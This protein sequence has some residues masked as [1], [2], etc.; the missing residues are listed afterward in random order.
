VPRPLNERQS[1]E[2][3]RAEIPGQIAAYRQELEN[4][5]PHKARRERLEWQIRERSKRLVDV[6][7]RLAKLPTE[8]VKNPTGRPREGGPSPSGEAG[9]GGEHPVA[10]SLRL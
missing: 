10:F 1:L 6:T 2:Q 7:A 4:G 5:R 8:K 3:E 9:C